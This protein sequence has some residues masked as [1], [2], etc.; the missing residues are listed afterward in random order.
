MQGAILGLKQKRAGLSK[1]AGWGLG[2][3]EDRLQQSLTILASW[4]ATAD[5][6]QGE[7]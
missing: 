3:G 4:M 7:A 6:S 1:E 5:D 2:S